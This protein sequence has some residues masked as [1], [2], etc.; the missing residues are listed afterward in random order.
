MKRLIIIIISLIVIIVVFC[1][2]YFNS[3]YYKLQLAKE[4]KLNEV[5]RLNS[6][7]R[8]YIFEGVYSFDN[9]ALSSESTKDKYD[10]F[11]T[12]F[13]TVNTGQGEVSFKSKKLVILFNGIREEFILGS[14]FLSLTALY[15]KV[16]EYDFPVIHWEAYFDLNKTQ[17]FHYDT[18]HNYEFNVEPWIKNSLFKGRPHIILR[19]ESGKSN[20]YTYPSSFFLAYNLP[21][22]REVGCLNGFISVRNESK[23]E[24]KELKYIYN[25]SVPDYVNDAS[26]KL[27]IL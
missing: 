16:T 12:T 24:L 1:F 14:P 10:E 11:V 5:S 9:E 20:N 18:L 6:I 26:V 7:P 23:I 15:D 25:N 13:E 2:I 8:T 4:D 19:A 22:T 3:N 27:S 17:F 21:W